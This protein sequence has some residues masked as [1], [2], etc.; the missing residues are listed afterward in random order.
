LPDKILHRLRAAGTFLEVDPGFLAQDQIKQRFE[1]PILVIGTQFD[2]NTPYVN[3]RRA[4]R[5]LGNAVLLTHHGYSHTSPLDPST[6]IQRAISAYLVELVTPPPGTVCPSDR[7][8][9]DPDFGKPL[10]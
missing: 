1:N 10:P 4:A 6:S 7:Q 9:F 2:P 8:P 3:A 5:R